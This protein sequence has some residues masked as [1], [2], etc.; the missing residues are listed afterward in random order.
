M[1]N[2]MIERGVDDLNDIAG[3]AASGGNEG[4]VNDMISR[5][6]DR[7]PRYLDAPH[8]N[9]REPGHEV[10]N[11]NYIAQRAAEGGHE[12]I[13]VDMLA[14]GADNFGKIRSVALSQGHGS[15]VRLVY[16]YQTR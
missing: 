6:A 11:F 12:K 5:G 1:P 10:P 13:V 3:A 14:R 16:S 8:P 7:V 9:N 15:I 2:D 4:I